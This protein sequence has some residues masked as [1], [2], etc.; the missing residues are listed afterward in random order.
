MMKFRHCEERS[1]AAIQPKGILYVADA[2]GWILTAFG[3][4]MTENHIYP[5]ALK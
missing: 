2:T 5:G 3:L 4:R 1:D